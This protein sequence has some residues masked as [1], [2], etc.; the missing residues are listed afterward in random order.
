MA[1]PKTHIYESNTLGLPPL[2]MVLVHARNEAQNAAMRPA[3]KLAQP[4]PAE[5]AAPLDTES[6]IRKIIERLENSEV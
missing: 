5:E 2:K 6:A 4:G 1:D 3:H